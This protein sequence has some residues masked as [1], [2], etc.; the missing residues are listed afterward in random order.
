MS[1]V[2][3]MTVLDKLSSRLQEEKGWRGRI[4]PVSAGYLDHNSLSFGS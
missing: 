1:S 3:G 4:H 2:A